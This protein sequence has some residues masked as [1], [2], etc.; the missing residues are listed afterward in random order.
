MKN[1]KYENII[2][3]E[4]FDFQVWTKFARTGQDEKIYDDLYNN[5]SSIKDIGKRLIIFFKKT[6]PTK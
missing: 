6:P 4:K 5:G 1:K 3:E 2:K